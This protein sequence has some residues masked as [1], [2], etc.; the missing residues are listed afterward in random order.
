MMHGN[1]KLKK[2]TV[3]FK[4]PTVVDH[5]GN[6]WFKELIQS[7]LFCVKYNNETFC[8]G[9]TTGLTMQFEHT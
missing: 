1:T 5:I 9:D 7:V 2:N 4:F 8:F 6:P 3:F